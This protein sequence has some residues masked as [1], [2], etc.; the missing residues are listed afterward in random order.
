M[1]TIKWIIL[2][3][4][5]F[6][7]I[8][9][10][11]QDSV[12][13]IQKTSNDIENPPTVIIQKDVDLRNIVHEVSREE[14]KTY[15]NQHD[16]LISGLIAL[17]GIVFGLVV[18]FIVNKS[19][20]KR[21]EKIS[22]SHEDTIREL[23][24]ESKKIINDKIQ[25]GIDDIESENR[26]IKENIEKNIIQLDERQKETE[27]VIAEII[28]S[29]NNAKT[30]AIGKILIRGNE[31]AEAWE[32][33]NDAIKDNESHN[34]YDTSLYK[35]RNDIYLHL[36][37][38]DEAIRDIESCEKLI[39]KE[40][41]IAKGW[42]MSTEELEKIKKLKNENVLQNIE[43]KIED[44]SFLMV[45]VESGTFLMGAPDNDTTSSEKEKPQ[46]PVLLSRPYYIGATP[47]T[48]LLW[49][50]IMGNNPSKYQGDNPTVFN[51]NI[52]D[53]Y[54]C[55]EYRPVENVSFYDV[56]D[57]IKKLN[58]ITGRIFRLPTEAEWEFAAI[59]GNEHKQYN[60]HYSGSNDIDQVAWYKSEYTYPVA[61]KKPNKLGLYDMCGNVWEWCGDY[62][63]KYRS[64][65]IA[66]PNNKPDNRGI[67][68]GGGWNSEAKSCKPTS[69][70]SNLLSYDDSRVGFRLVLEC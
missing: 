28:P 42:M 52:P 7:N 24:A 10:M 16:L 20:E 23:I 65:S 4:I 11:A 8:D 43:I 26:K 14:Y 1:K 31:F 35:M 57:F 29:I 36:N 18:P 33:I 3:L 46:H 30:A 59:G 27:K 69:R 61:Q 60:F 37:M 19:Y 56:Q 45:Y 21:L 47:V 58:D 34:H 63:D 25:N 39:E 15:I 50:M 5:V 40:K 64:S 70:Y 9:T 22:S 12:G 41:N 13:P 55:N 62:C 38:Y 6:S 49:T 54:H 48:Q 53:G 68:R 32:Y 67:Y 2:F 17:I 66:N 44:Y 51:G